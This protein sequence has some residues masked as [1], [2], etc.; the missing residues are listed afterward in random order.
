MALTPPVRLRIMKRPAGFS[1]IA[2]AN[3]TRAAGE[4]NRRR[5]HGPRFLEFRRVAA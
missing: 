3:T 1:A 2:A 4:R 5:R